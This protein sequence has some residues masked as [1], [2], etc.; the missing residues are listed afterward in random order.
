MAL[1][2]DDFHRTHFLKHIVERA[3]EC[4]VSGSCLIFQDEVIKSKMVELGL[5]KS[6]A[7]DDGQQDGLDATGAK[8]KQ[9]KKGTKDE[10]KAKKDKKK[11]TDVTRKKGKGKK[12]T[13]V[14][15]KKVKKKATSGK[16]KPKVASGDEESTDDDESASDSSHDD[17]SS[18]EIQAA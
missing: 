8:A 7:A 3:V 10:K 12:T 5:S 16:K 6:D 15:Q 13:D 4:T 9:D 11:T 2:H 17:A 14:T 18:G 1:C